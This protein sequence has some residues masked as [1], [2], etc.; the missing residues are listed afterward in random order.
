[1][2]AS[3]CKWCTVVQGQARRAGRSSD[4]CSLAHGCADRA[5]LH[6]EPDQHH[7]IAHPQAGSDHPAVAI[8]TRRNQGDLP[9]A[10]EPAKAGADKCRRG[11]CAARASRIAWPRPMER[12]QPHIT[13]HRRCD[14]RTMGSIAMTHP[15]ELERPMDSLAKLIAFAREALDQFWEGDGTMQDLGEKHGLLVPTIMDK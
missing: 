2:H 12:T 6:R 10:Q 7:F 11:T 15:S 8:R 1:M 5:H 3:R 14:G 4:V 9:L 13:G